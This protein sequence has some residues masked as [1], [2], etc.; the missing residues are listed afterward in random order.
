MNPELQHDAPLFIA[1]QGTYATTEV[2]LFKGDVCLSLD[3]KESAKASST[4]VPSLDKLLKE[5]GVK[6]SDV[7]FIAVDQGPGAFTSLRVAITTVNALNFSTQI[8]LIGVDGLDALA[9]STQKKF[10]NLCTQGTSIIALLNA[11]NNE[12]YHA[13]YE[14]TT[15]SILTPRIAKSYLPIAQ[16]LEMLA[17]YLEDAPEPIIFTGNGSAMHRSLITNAFGTRALV[18]EDILTHADCITIAEHGMHIWRTD[19]THM[20]NK[21]LPLYL[22]SQ[23]FAVRQKPGKTP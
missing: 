9:R 10:P 17:S 11:Y 15:P 13:A 7:A 8:P 5:H 21:L 3:R 14:V 22:K 23:H 1:L 4:L 2:G 6:L 12:V 16:C 18:P 19:R 20:R